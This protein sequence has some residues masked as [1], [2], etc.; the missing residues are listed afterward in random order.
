MYMSNMVD[1]MPNHVTVWMNYL[2]NAI[3]EGD[4]TVLG[5]LIA[6][7]L[8]VLTFLIF[9]VFRQRGNKRRGVLILGSCD[10]GKTLLFTRLVYGKYKA[11]F[12]SITANSGTYTLPDTGKTLRILD[13][14]GHERVRLQMLETH[15]DVTRAI[16]F[17]VDSSSVQKDIKDIAEYLYTV[18][19]DNKISS[20]CPPV[21]IVCNKQDLTF[22]KGA[23]VIQGQLEKEMN[24]L[25]ITKSAALQD[26][27]A[28]NNNTY[29]GK[30]DRDFTFTDLKP[31]RVEFAECSAQGKNSE[32]EPD[33]KQVEEWLSRI[34]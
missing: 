24:T 5:I 14:P 17:V 13:L 12:T 23:K 1:R 3:D 6:V 32:S 10:A 30:R 9:G 26:T 31:M 19:S 33:L 21:L 2:K 16:M 25:R 20:I 11:T 8:V 27:S 7:I 29:L 22:S 34:A 15:K 28:G 18:L 4:Y